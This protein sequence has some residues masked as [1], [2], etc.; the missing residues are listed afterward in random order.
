MR[1]SRTG[2]VQ[3]LLLA[4]GTA[5]MAVPGAAQGGDQAELSALAQEAVE[6]QNDVL[7]SGDVEGSLRGRA[8][9]ARFRAG[10]Q[11][12]LA[13]LTHRKNVLARTRNDYKSHRTT[14]R[15]NDTRVEGD[16][17][18]QRGTEHVVLA[19]DPSIGGPP[20]TEYTQEHVFKYQK[21]GGQWT[22]VEDEVLIPP[23]LPEEI[24]GPAATPAATEA[25]AGYKPNPNT[26]RRRAGPQ[27]A[28]LS[29]TPLFSLASYSRR[30]TERAFAYNPTA[31]VN[32]A[33]TYWGPYNSNYN[34]S[35]REY[36]NDCTNFI[37]QAMKAGGWVYDD[38]GDRTASNTWYYGTFTATTSYSWAGA[39]NFNTFF[40]QSGRG[41]ALSHVNDLWLG[42]VLQA[43]FGPTPDGN[44]SHS[45]IVT[46][47]DANGVAYL[48]YHTGNT[49]NRSVNDIVAG[50]PGSR[51][52][53]L[54]MYE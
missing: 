39:H 21:T 13:N 22:L 31:A 51:W 32:Y 8:N 37:S 38:V 23:P 29:Q 44:I 49:R 42:D 16:R 52:Y 54:A 14:V 45:M 28:F 5:I 17:A 40:A 9:A 36:P 30:S 35:Y 12:N 50:N 24:R 10:I 25:P 11:R 46:H 4:L 53:A 27:G 2:G 20:N 15:V 7:V 41:W 34:S 43:D 19:L 6:A 47:K 48:T 26:E 18:T 3:V 33:L 1:Q